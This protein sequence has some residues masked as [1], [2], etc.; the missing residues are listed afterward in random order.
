MFETDFFTSTWGFQ[1]GSFH[2]SDLNH[3][4]GRGKRGF[5]DQAVQ[6]NDHIY[7]HIII[8]KSPLQSLCQQMVVP[9]RVVLSLP[10]HYLIGFSLDHHHYPQV[11][12]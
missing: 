7:L 12:H 2:S 1:L 10:E 9:P 4:N 8:H 5:T 6:A 11:S 3:G